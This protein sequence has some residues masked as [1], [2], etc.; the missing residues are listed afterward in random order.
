MFREITDGFVTMINADFFGP[1]S[2]NLD[3]HS[4][5]RRSGITQ[6]TKDRSGDRPCVFN[7][8]KAVYYDARTRR[9]PPAE[10]FDGHRYGR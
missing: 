9:V 5:I 2:R 1:T 4:G 10:F 8:R 7:E 6:L 3:V